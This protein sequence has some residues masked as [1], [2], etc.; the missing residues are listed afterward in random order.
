MNKLFKNIIFYLS[1]VFL[2][3]ASILDVSIAQD[4]LFYN[5]YIQFAGNNFKD[6]GTHFTTYFY[7]GLRYQTKDY[8]LSFSLPFIFTDNSSLYQVGNM[9]VTND[10]KDGTAVQNTNTI[11]RHGVNNM[12][13]MQIGIGD[14]YVYG[15]YNLLSP[16][17]NLLQ[18]TLDGYIKAPTAVSS[19]NYGTG[20]FDYSISFSIRKNYNSFLL[21]T[22][23]GYLV[24]GDTETID[25]KNP[26]TMSLGL[27]SNFNSLNH[28]LYIGYDS[29][30]TII[31]GIESPQQLSLGYSYMVNT[32]L[33]Y[34]FIAS[35]GLNSSASDFLIS[36]GINIGLL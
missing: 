33:S 19:F 25:Y 16:D 7:N 12:S 34:N 21:Y 29:F 13:T 8:S 2:I 14:L 11:M 23:L 32:S 22:Q 30:S 28:A 26:L 3:S 1:S 36:G 27:G 9:V 20:Q 35:Y 31:N 24:L 10:S 17:Y 4:K 5:G 18:I 6:G 15:S